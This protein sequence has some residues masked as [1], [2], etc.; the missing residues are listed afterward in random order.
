[1][2]SVYFFFSFGLLCLRTFA[3]CLF[4]GNVDE[5]SKTSIKLL[6]CLNIYNT[7]S[8][9]LLQQIGTMKIALTG[10]N[11]FTVTRGLILNIAAAIVTYEV[12]F[13]QYINT[14]ED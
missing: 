3:V 8:K 9:R 14:I 7:E 1:M 5:E 10:M 12:F 4:V 2:E 13:I 11:F 6:S